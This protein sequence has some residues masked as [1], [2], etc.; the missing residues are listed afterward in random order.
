M[1]MLRDTFKDDGKLIRT[2][3]LHGEFDTHLSFSRI[4]WVLLDSGWIIADT[5]ISFIGLTLPRLFLR[6]HYRWNRL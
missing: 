4:I 5:F 3:H 1:E 6:R 2:L